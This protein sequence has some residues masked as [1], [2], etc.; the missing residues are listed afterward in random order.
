MQE[1]GQQLEELDVL[2]KAA[3][4]DEGRLLRGDD[5]LEVGAQAAGQHL[6]QQPVVGV[7]EGDGAVVGGVQA[8]TGLLV[9]L[10]MMTPSW[11]P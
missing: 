1:V 6:G 11:K 7:E 4:G 10:R 2:P 9:E 5:G 3:A 8:V